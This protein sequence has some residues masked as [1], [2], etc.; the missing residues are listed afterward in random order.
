VSGFVA[1]AIRYG[2]PAVLVLAGLVCLLVVPP[3]TRF[4]AWALFTGA[5][6][7]VLLLNAL[8]RIGVQGEVERDR[9]D[10]ARAFFDE[11][12]RWPDA[13]ERP[14]KRE[15]RLPEGIAT[16]ESEAAEARR[17]SQDESTS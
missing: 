4:E 3:G 15:W 6:L 13:D 2:I 1:F 9:E 5:G 8:F 11:H 12:G 16:P 10:A 7:S 17:R 14:K